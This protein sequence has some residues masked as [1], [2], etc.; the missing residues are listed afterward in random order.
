MSELD[1]SISE[2]PDVIHSATQRAMPGASLI[3]IAATD[4]RPLTSG[5]SPSSGNPS[6]VSESRPLI[7][8][9][10]PTR[11]SPRI[12]GISSSACSS[13]SS[14]SSF[15]KGNSVGESL[16]CSREGISSGSHR[17]GRWS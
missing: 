3:Q 16:D 5:V 8:C 15:V 17:I 7:A 10:M 9:R 1:G 13:D 6:G 14:K 11:G 12:S 2:T 4:H